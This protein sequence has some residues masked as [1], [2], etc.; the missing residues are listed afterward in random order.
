M[1][2]LRRA[3]VALL[4]TGLALTS[5]PGAPV[6]AATAKCQG[7]PATLVGTNGPDRLV[8]T[9]KA[10][11]IV[12]LGGDDLIDGGG[13]DDLICGGAGADRL[14]G[15]PGADR[16]YGGT[17][18]LVEGP[19]GS[20]LVG[21]VLIGGPGSDLLDGGVDSREADHR[22]RPDTFS[23]ADDATGPVT[24]DLAGLPPAGAG[25]AAGEGVGSDTIVL[26]RAHGI[27]ATPYA[28]RIT[29]SSGPDRVLAGDGGDLVVTGGG[30]DLVY[31]D[32]P[33]GTGR[34][35]VET[36]P[37][38]D[39]VS[40]TAGR[41]RIVTGRG[42]DFVEAFGAD[43]TAVEL[44]PG[45]DYLGVHVVPG[46]GAGADGGVGNDTVAFYG[47]RLAG[48]QPPARF[49]ID[50]RTGETSA[51]GEVTAAGTIGGFE[52]HRL[53][54]PLRW[55]FAGSDEADRVWAIEGG[56]LRAR[57]HDGADMVTGTDEDDVIVGGSG[58]DTGYGRGGD[59]VCR[60]VE[61]GDC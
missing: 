47:H 5:L 53:L 7:K 9:D 21:D 39:L 12:G 34:D 45:A 18:A 26:G 37:G 51:T 61:R 27:V 59:D 60:S 11:V 49:V 50:L 6:Q 57:T 54:G 2:A 8:G 1:P 33:E 14:L 22:R 15:G 25:T 20:Y 32:G 36:G 30:V 44:G 4:V 40:S 56:P 48:Q 52:R 3:L 10:D 19:G 13:G 31:A 29:G 17:D 55:R 42:A 46:K 35:V 38:S 24:V 41:D 16:L 43:P 58:R 23:W 28:D